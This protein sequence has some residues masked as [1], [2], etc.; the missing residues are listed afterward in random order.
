MWLWFFF[1]RYLFPCEFLCRSYTPNTPGWREQNNRQLPGWRQTR[2]LRLEQVWP[3]PVRWHSPVCVGSWVRRVGNQN[4]ERNPGKNSL[5]TSWIDDADRSISHIMIKRSVL[6][7]FVHPWAS[8][9]KIIF[10]QCYFH[11]FTHTDYFFLSF[12]RPDTIALS[13]STVYNGE[14]S[15]S[16]KFAKWLCRG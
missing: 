9:Y 2:A 3:T 8:V 16:F 15:R 13:S 4:T 1:Q 5:Y 14:K 11:P 10:A 12:I 7:I 6:N